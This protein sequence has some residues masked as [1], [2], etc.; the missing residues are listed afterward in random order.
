MID[1]GQLTFDILG[2]A[3]S[4]GLP[5]FLWAVLFLCAFE[6]PA[7]AES[8]G[9]GRRAFWLLLPG[10]AA[11]TLA[12]LPFLP[13]SN[14]LLGISVGGALFPILV[15]LLAFGPLAP[16]MRRSAGLF[17]AAYGIVAGLG[18]AVVVLF[19][20]ATPSTLGVV[21]LAAAVPAVV[22]LLGRFRRDGLLERVAGLLAL[23]DGV[24]VLTFLFS[25]AIPGVGI[26]EMFPQYLLPPI[27]AGL[28]VALAAPRLLRGAEGLALPAAYI[29]GT[30]GVLV[31]ADVLREPP[32]YPSSGPGLYVIGGAGILDLVYLSG[33]LAFATAYVIHYAMGSAWTPIPG[34]PKE[35]PPPT[36][37]GQLGRSFRQGVTG[38]LSGSLVSA[39][40]ATHAAAH[41]AATVLG[42]PPA[43][44]DRPWQGLPVPGW[45]VSDQANLD[46]AAAQ[47]TNDGRESYRGWL[48]ARSLVALSI[49][50]VDRKFASAGGRALAFVLDL[51]VVTVPAVA[52]WAYLAAHTP[53]GLT[54]VLSSVAYN[55]AIYGY[56]SLAYL[57]FVVGETVFG[58]TVGKRL[59]GFVVRER[60]LR[61]TNLTSGL[62]RNAFRVPTLSILGV[63]VGSATGLLVA[64][65]N[66]GAVSFEGLPLPAGIL[67]AVSLLV[68]AILSVGLLGLVGFLSITATSERQRWGDLV[69]G[70]WVLR[71]PTAVPPA[72]PPAPAAGPSG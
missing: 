40:T 41:E 62:L 29:A 16:P 42:V 43:P 20:A 33:L 2:N 48:T 58:T 46:A 70:T 5:G 31:G 72:P 51:L 8:I 11:V 64:G 66:S 56:I 9:L 45:V 25:A 71:S 60:E 44:T 19:P 59:L 10:A 14:D 38:D 55:A 27:G 50:L 17:L 39:S 3:I 34:A 22:F 52:V 26:S 6:H 4:V 13:V 24:L 12:D 30:F 69:A 61:P 23:T 63:A 67:A 36:P 37:M 21:L 35:S 53:G 28:L 65:A 18:L 1:P 47:G 7:F 15:A 49:Q 68:G 32:L 57:Y 54:A